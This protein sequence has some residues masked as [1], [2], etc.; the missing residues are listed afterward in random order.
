WWSTVA[1]VR[2]GC[3]MFRPAARRPSTGWGG[4]TSWPGGRSVYEHGASRGG[5]ATRCSSQTFSN[6]VRGGA[7]FSGTDS[8][9][10]KFRRG[11]RFRLGE[12]LRQASVAGQN[13]K[14]PN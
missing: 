3:R 5:A 13:R 14:L 1:T 6:R 2:G 11:C 9:S 4:G 7:I 8:L 12:D 10:T